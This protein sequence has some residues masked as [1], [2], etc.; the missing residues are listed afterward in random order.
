MCTCL[1]LTQ[2]RYLNQTYTMIGIR[3]TQDLLLLSLL[4]PSLLG[5]AC[6]ANDGDSSLGSDSESMEE[7]AL[8][9]PNF[10]D[11]HIQN[12]LV[13]PNGEVMIGIHWGQKKSICAALG[14]GIAVAKSYHDHN[15]HPTQVSFSPSMHGCLHGYFIQA[16]YDVG[17]KKTYECVLLED[18]NGA[19]LAPTTCKHDGKGINEGTPSTIYGFNNPIMRACPGGHAMSGLHIGGNDLYC[20]G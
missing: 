12:D 4:S 15:A 1:N 11:L 9:P 18:A 8:G 2:Y 20:C 16:V 10:V 19:E 6:V 14:N 5:L 3:T 13:C 7:R 17:A